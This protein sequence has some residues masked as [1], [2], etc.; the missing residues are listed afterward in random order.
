MAVE[1]TVEGVDMQ[2]L[3]RML[4]VLVVVM[5]VTELPVPEGFDT[6]RRDGVATAS[7]L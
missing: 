7:T 2:T 5:A 3:K 4:F 6:S 1:T